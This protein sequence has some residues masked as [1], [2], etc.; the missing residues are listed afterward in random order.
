MT[1]KHKTF[2]P[3]GYSGRRQCKCDNC[4]HITEEANLKPLTQVHHLGSRL[5]AGYETP[6]G[7]CLECG[8]FSYLL[9]EMT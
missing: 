7:E 2:L 5:D 3:E 6:A 9:K 4:S 8:A 1:Y